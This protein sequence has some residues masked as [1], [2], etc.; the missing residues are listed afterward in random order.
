[1]KQIVN[2]RSQIIE[3]GKQLGLN[4]KQMHSILNN[5]SHTIEQLSFSQGPPMYGGSYY[6][7]I[8][9]N[10]FNIRKKTMKK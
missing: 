3:L 10:A 4:T 7:T 6:G 2:P 8:S 5:T 1:M 9:I